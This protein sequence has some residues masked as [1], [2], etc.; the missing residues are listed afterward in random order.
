MTNSYAETA[1]FALEQLLE[2]AKYLEDNNELSYERLKD[3]V[4]ST[5]KA[6]GDE[7]EAENE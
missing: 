3:R 6:V 7:T 5:K 4:E 2:Y 1:I